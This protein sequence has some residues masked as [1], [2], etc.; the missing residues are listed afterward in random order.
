M[1]IFTLSFL[2]LY[3]LASCNS[4]MPKENG[5]RKITAGRETL[6]YNYLY[7]NSDSEIIKNAYR[8]DPFIEFN[9]YVSYDG[10][11]ME[12][13]RLGYRENNSEKVLGY[14]MLDTVNNRTYECNGYG[15]SVVE[16]RPDLQ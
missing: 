5:S 11:S 14:L 4:P 15:D 13:Y 6:I 1:R 12:L 7:K 10:M 16:W 2:F 8:E 3:G 9:K